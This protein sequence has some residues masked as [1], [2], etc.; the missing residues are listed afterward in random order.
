MKNLSRIFE[1]KQDWNIPKTYGQYLGW[2]D[3]FLDLTYKILCD[4]SCNFLGFLLI[5]I[6]WAGKSS[7]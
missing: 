7:M 5:P 2:N 4:F 6:I 3:N 1:I